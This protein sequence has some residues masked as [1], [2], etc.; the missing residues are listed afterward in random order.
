M[1]F[2]HGILNLT[3][4]I[5]NVIL[6]TLA[7]LFFAL[8][9]LRFARSENSSLTVYGGFLCLLSSGM[10]RGLEAFASQRSPNDPDVYWIAL[11]SLVDWVCNVMMPMYAGLQVAAGA[12][13]MGIITRVHPTEGWMKH[14]LAAALCLL[15]SGLLRLAEF[16]VTHGTG[17]VA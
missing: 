3:N 8:A 2:T 11:V 14:F 13:R 16:F 5:A 10:L 7:G 12:L 15:L 17:G 6:P 1:S 4:W 9:I